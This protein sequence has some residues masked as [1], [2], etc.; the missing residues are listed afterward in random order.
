VTRI[1]LL[2]SGP[3]GL[4]VHPQRGQPL[5]VWIRDHARAGTLVV[6]PAITYY[7][8]RREL[9]RM[10]RAAA[11]AHLDG[12]ARSLAHAEVT[13]AVLVRASE[14]WAEARRRGRP[15]A[16]DRALDVDMILAATAL[17]LLAPGDDVVVATT[18]AR[19]L[20][21]FVPTATWAEITP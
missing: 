1:V 17:E 11:V 2:D 12:F 9:V 14:L 6:M 21:Q 4:L 3:L 16:D 10:N 20:G 18:N 15:T 13:T 5:E 19:H 8:L 7:E